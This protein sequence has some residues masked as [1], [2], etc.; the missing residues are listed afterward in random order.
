MRFVNSANHIRL[1]LV[2][3]VWLE[4]ALLKGFLHALGFGLGFRAGV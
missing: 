4:S 3:K 2:R 1:F